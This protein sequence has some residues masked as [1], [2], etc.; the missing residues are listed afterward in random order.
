[1]EEK[2]R[3]LLFIFACLPIRILYIYLAKKASLKYL[4]YLGIIAIMIG[5]SFIYQSKKGK[6]TGGF[7]GPAWWHPVRNIHGI[8]WILFGI[9]AVMRKKQA[10]VVLIIDIII[11]II[12]FINNYYV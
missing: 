7:G 12:T 3:K 2:Y 6:K 8:L 11:G 1:M 4:F 5:T 10:Y 9:L